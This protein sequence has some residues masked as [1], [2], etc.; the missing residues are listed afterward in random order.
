QVRKERVDVALLPVTHEVGMEL[1]RPCHPAF[2][3]RKAQGGE[4][5]GYTAQHERLAEPVGRVREVPNVVE[6]GVG[7]G[8]P[9]GPADAAAVRGHGDSRTLAAP[10]E[11]V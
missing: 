10:P 4:A 1:T 9:V 8:G 6:H 2:E 7:R 5:S 11:R 3:E